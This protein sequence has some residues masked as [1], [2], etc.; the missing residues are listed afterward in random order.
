[1]RT[2]LSRKCRRPS[3]MSRATRWRNGVEKVL[4]G[5]LTEKGRP[6]EKERFRFLGNEKGREK[7]GMVNELRFSHGAVC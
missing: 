7:G 6:Y 4:P 1:M 3:N 5:P 2:R